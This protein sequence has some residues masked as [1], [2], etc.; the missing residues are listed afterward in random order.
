MYF[1][2]INGKEETRKFDLRNDK[3]IFLGCYDSSKSPRLYNRRILVVYETI[4]TM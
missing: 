2:H 3:R 4:K 1:I